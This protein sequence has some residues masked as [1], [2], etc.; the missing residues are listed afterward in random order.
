[1]SL[2]HWPIRV[3][4]AGPFFVFSS[5]FFF[6]F[7]PPLAAAGGSQ[8]D[9]GAKV[10]RGE[11]LE[12]S[13]CHSRAPLK[14]RETW[15]GL[16]YRALLRRHEFALGIS[17]HPRLSHD[18]KPPLGRRRPCHVFFFTLTDKWGTRQRP[19][20]YPQAPGLCFSLFLFFF[21]RPSRRRGQ[22]TF[23]F[24]DYRSSLFFPAFPRLWGARDPLRPRVLRS[25]NA[26]FSSSVAES[27]LPNITP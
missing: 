12:E 4:P 20:F 8:S 23:K 21:F 18:G 26:F 2:A 25:G 7:V 1:M 3:L 11:S 10:W 17:G 24:Q 9:R 5:L 14:Y 15:S 16:R 27:L 6:F 22:F 13:Y 19:H